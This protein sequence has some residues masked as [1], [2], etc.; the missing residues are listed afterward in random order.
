MK[1]KPRYTIEEIRQK[2]MPVAKRHKLVR[3]YLFGSYARGD[4]KAKSDIDI[5]VDVPADMDYFRLCEVYGD[6]ERSLNAKV[7]LLTTG[8]LEEK[9]LNRIAKEE[10]LLYAERT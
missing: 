8:A 3:M 7:D 1:R 9:F 4:A 5:R 2:V 10:V 6:L